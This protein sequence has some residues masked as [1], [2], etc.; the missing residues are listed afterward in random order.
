[1]V[2]T[3]SKTKYMNGLQCPRLLWFCVN[4]PEAMPP[5]DEE[6]Q[7]LFDQGHEVGNFAKMLFPEGIEV[8]HDGDMVKNT[9]NSLTSER[10]YLRP[11]CLITK[12]LQNPI[13]LN[14]WA[15]KSGIL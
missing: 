2:S 7:F 8:P 3:I 11:P 13:F 10:R 9:R 4:Q 6:T 14:R 5:V 15:R 1:M 12:L